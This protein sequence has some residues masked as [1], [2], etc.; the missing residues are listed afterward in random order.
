M[1]LTL[2]DYAMVHY[3][4]SE[5]AAAALCLSQLLLEDLAWVSGLQAVGLV[6]LLL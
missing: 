6:H 4:P 2:L 1:E 3:L 5:I